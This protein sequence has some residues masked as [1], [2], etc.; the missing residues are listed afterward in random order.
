M[1]FRVAMLIAAAFLLAACSDSSGPQIAAN[2]KATADAVNAANQKIDA[3]QKVVD[4]LIK[5]NSKKSPLMV[6]EVQCTGNCPQEFCKKLGYAK[7]SDALPGTA[8]SN[9]ASDSS[10]Q[11]RAGP[12]SAGQAGFGLTS[13]AC[14][15]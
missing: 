3:L 10:Y 4:D 13:F 7:A 6:S 11:L 5:N 8:W 12:P 9:Q 1:T 15:D 2:T 14:L